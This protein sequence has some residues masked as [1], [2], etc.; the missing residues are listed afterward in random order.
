MLEI[1]EN[2]PDT[3]ISD[4]NRIKQVLLNLLVNANKFTTLGSIWVT[5]E[6]KGN[7]IQIKVKDDGIGIKEED[8]EK[9]FTAFK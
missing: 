4:K 1:D 5:C 2:F 3:V 7:L 6:I 9:L 8:Q